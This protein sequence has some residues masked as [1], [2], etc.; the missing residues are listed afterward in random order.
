MTRVGLGERASKKF[1]SKFWSLEKASLSAA[2]HKG[3]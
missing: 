2:P 1:P 3:K